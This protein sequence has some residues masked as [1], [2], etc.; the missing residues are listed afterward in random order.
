MVTVGLLPAVRGFG[1]TEL[2]RGALAAAAVPAIS[3]ET[4]RGATTFHKAFMSMSSTF[5]R[6]VYGLV[7]VLFS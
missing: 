7:Q 3:R 5:I 4:Q 2:I 1:E 6:L